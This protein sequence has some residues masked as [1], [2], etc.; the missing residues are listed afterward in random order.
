[1]AA[2]M[3]TLDEVYAFTCEEAQS[4][5]RNRVQISRLKLYIFKE[6][7]SLRFSC[8][9]LACPGLVQQRWQ[10]P[11]SPP[12]NGHSSGGTLT[13]MPAVETLYLK[14][15]VHGSATS[16]LTMKSFFLRLPRGWESRLL[17]ETR[18][19]QLQNL[20]IGLTS[21]SCLQFKLPN[22]HWVKVDQWQ[23]GSWKKAGFLYSQIS[24]GFVDGH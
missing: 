11:I 14:R 21:I 5:W 24:K 6:F 18:T 17:K 8:M 12:L 7:S 16:C 2:V 1:M 9:G 13:S 10:Q 15:E 19:S 22:H 3:S 4:N 20:E 23:L